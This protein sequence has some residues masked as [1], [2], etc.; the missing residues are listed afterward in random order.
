MDRINTNKHNDE[1]N[2][3]R[4]FK[5]KKVIAL[6]MSKVLGI[7]RKFS[8]AFGEGEYYKLIKDIYINITCTT[9]IIPITC[10]Y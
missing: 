2:L 6:Q 5:G 9:I 8:L 10:K 7:F 3:A 4:I 1:K